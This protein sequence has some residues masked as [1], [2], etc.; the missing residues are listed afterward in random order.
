MYAHLP[1]KERRNCKAYH[2]NNKLW[3]L[4]ILDVGGKGL[5]LQRAQWFFIL[6]AIF[7]PGHLIQ[8]TGCIARIGS[9]FPKVNIIDFNVNNCTKELFAILTGQ[10]AVL[11]LFTVK[12][13]AAEINKHIKIQT[14]LP[15]TAGIGRHQTGITRCAPKPKTGYNLKI[16]HFLRMLPPLAHAHLIFQRAYLQAHCPIFVS[17]FNELSRQGS[18]RTSY[19]AWL[20]KPANLLVNPTDP[21]NKVDYTL[22]YMHRD[23]HCEERAS[24]DKVHSLFS[25]TTWQE[26]TKAP[27]RSPTAARWDWCC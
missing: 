1:N 3:V 2:P 24:I 26:N 12:T 7:T 16:N 21:T 23:P 20:G 25:V 6:L 14:L 5:N 9:A 15:R 4:L 17:L 10:K 22:I 27:W 18:L 13:Y 19:N 8:L 11:L